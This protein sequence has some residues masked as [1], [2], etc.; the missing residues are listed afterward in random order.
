VNDDS[1]ARSVGG[2]GLPVYLTYRD[3]KQVRSKMGSWDVA[4]LR[5][6]LLDGLQ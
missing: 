3:G 6:A 1:F 5:K 2:A 4:E